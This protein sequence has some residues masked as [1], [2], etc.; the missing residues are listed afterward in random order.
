MRKLRGFIPTTALLVTLAFGSTVANAGI[1]VGQ[2]AETS[3][4]PCKVETTTS[5]L[6]DLITTISRFAITGIVVGQ[7]L[8]TNKTCGI[9][10]GQ[11]VETN[12]GGIVVGQ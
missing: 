1:V 10:V 2:I 8:E 9:V 4:D 5:V 7:S 6:T 3:D 11:A 12:K